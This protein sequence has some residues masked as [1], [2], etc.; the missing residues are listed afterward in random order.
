MIL[1]PFRPPLLKTLLAIL[2]SSLTPFQI[3]RPGTLTTLKPRGDCPVA[4]NIPSALC[5]Q[6]PRPILTLSLTKCL[7]LANS[8]F[9]VYVDFQQ[10][11]K[12]EDDSVDAQNKLDTTIL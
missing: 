7:S 11:I 12:P 5:V 8:R 9:N 10:I 6:P 3:L 2:N 1:V 4:E